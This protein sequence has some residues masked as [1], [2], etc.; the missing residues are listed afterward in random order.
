MQHTKTFFFVNVILFTSLWK[1]FCEIVHTNKWGTRGG[2]LRP[3]DQGKLR[4][5]PGVIWVEKSV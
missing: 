3:Q 5:D 1:N 4:D 2:V